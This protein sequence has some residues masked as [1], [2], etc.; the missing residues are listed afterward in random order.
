MAKRQT[1]EVR[2]EGISIEF[3]EVKADSE[4]DA[5]QRWAEGILTAT[6]GHSYE[7]VSVTEYFEDDDYEEVPDD[8]GDS[9]D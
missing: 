3:Y 5:K 2:V 8:Q 1:Y 9:L 6:D 7:V 4:E